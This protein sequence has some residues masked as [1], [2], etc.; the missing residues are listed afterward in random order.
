METALRRSKTLFHSDKKTSV[1]CLWK[2]GEEGSYLKNTDVKIY[3][4]G[5]V[6]IDDFENKETVTTHISNVV[7]I[8]EK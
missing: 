2:R 6:M 7:I 3:G 8:Q 1:L 4:D 5:I